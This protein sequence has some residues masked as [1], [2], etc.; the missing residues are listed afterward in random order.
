MWWVKGRGEDG[1]LR[2]GLPGVSALL[3]GEDWHPPYRLVGLCPLDHDLKTWGSHEDIPLQVCHEGSN[4]GAD[5]GARFDCL[6]MAKKPKVRH[7]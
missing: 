1:R 4:W 3:D 6:S 2:L 5:G 7:T